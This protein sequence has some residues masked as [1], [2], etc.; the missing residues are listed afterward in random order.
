M[1]QHTKLTTVFITVST[2][3]IKISATKATW[4]EK[5]SFDLQLSG[6]TPLL[7]E[8]EGAEGWS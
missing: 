3:E 1:P 7:R 8:G 4:G 5:V 2:A 6:H